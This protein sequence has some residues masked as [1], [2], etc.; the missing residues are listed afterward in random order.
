M[1]WKDD[2]SLTIFNEQFWGFP[3]LDFNENVYTSVIMCGFMLL[4]I[5]TVYTVY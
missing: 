2:K 4:Y 5:Y 3:S 1:Q